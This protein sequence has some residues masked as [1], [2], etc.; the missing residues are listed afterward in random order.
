MLVVPRVH[1]PTLLEL[2]DA[3]IA[4]LFAAVKAVQRKV[5]RALAPPG[6]NVGWN[7]GKPAGQHVFHLHVH[8]LPRFAD[9]GRGVQALGSGGERADIGAIATAIRRA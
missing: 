6:M 1:A 3:A 8:V 7:H 9:G 2:E 4:E 5:Q